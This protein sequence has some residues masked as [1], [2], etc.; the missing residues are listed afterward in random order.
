MN[1]YP[2]IFL[3][4]FSFT[5]VLCPLPADDALPVTEL[6]PVT[7]VAHAHGLPLRV[8]FDPKAPAQPIPAQ[9]GAEVLRAVPGIHVIRKGGTDGDPVLRG[10]A[11]SRLGIVL[12]G[13]EILGGC[14]NRMDPPTAYVF[15]AAFD[16]VTVVK[17][18]Q[19]VRHGPGQTAGVVLFDRDPTPFTA[20][21]VRLAGAAT[22]GAH[23]R[24]DQFVDARAGD[25]AMQGR[26]ALTRSESGD[27]SDGGGR[28]VHSAYERWSAQ[29]A[30]TWTPAEGAFVEVSG[31]LSDGEA[32]YADR[33]M[34][35]VK[36]A[37]ENAAVSWSARPRCSAV[38]S[39]SGQFYY[40]YI[41]HVMDNFTLRKFSPTMMMPGRTASNPDR[42]TFGARVQAVSDEL[43]GLVWT[44]GADYRGDQH[45]V[46]RTTDAEANPYTALPRRRDARF[47]VTGLYAE[48]EYTPGEGNA[49]R[50]VFGLRGDYWRAEDSRA[51]V[52]A[53]MG[54]A[55]PN[56]TAGARR[57]EILPSGFIRYERRLGDGV[58]A[59]A[60]LG[61][62]R[63][64][65][66]YW[67][68]F[69][70]ESVGSVSA[71]G[72][73]PE[74]VTQLDA[75]ATAA[76][77]PVAASLSLFA[78]RMDDFLLIE[79]GYVKTDG[80][81]NMRTATVTR[82]IDAR[83]VGGEATAAV[84]FADHWR[85]D[86]SLAYVR[87]TNRTDGLPLA[88]QPP[89]EGR[90]GLHYDR[91]EWAAGG[92]VRASRRQHRVAPDQGNIV[93]QDLGPTPGF[94]VFSA[95]AA[96]RPSAR[97]R[98]TAGVDNVFDKLFAEH[99][100]RGGALVAGFPAPTTRVNEPGRVWW[101]RADVRF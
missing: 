22:V 86:A 15:P 35:G 85:A 70:K 5:T 40:N 13:Q 49:D 94:A 34:D 18:P 71:F 99:L 90:L 31:V 25:A 9:D 33:G 10:M 80:M 96:W 2:K 43:G 67:E 38:E 58:T 54:P 83:A 42:E 74:R 19:S 29:G 59:Y 7:V 20:P 60:G 62:A 84:R 50:F 47:D 57:T 44:A 98:V 97:M 6:P 89:A 48:G 24:N 26:F 81:G 82:N 16:R 52:A 14:G 21:T 88:Q 17:G 68:L 76:L 61:H 41:D 12:D 73:A 63:R 36:F 39:L 28:R 72:A 8:E 100:S 23:G 69:N 65:P 53:G 101:V 30:V 75:G 55:L 91:G 4:F 37:R 66:D 1:T 46:R 93:G 27:Y 64:F 92:L 32:A 77:G 45:S 87:G 78:N 56:P 51:S 11:G 95:Y 3:T 79:R